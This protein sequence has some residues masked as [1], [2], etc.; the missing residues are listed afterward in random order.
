M[1]IYD[2]KNQIQTPLTNFIG[3][4]ITQINKFT[5]NNSLKNLITF[6]QTAPNSIKNQI[7]IVNYYSHLY[8]SYY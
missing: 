2:I 7:S 6:S 1:K 5:R 4:W 3:I 8:S